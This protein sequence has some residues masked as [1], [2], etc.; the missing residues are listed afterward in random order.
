MYRYFFN[1]CLVTLGIGTALGVAA[2]WVP[3]SWYQVGAKLIW[4]DVVLFVSS[5][6]GA[7]LCKLGDN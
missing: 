6:A 3:E 7:L 5:I 1:G 4:T 2:V